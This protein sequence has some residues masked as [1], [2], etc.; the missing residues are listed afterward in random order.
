[1][2]T[3]SR[4]NSDVALHSSSAHSSA[5]HT[6]KA[7]AVVK[8]RKLIRASGTSAAITTT[9]SDTISSANTAGNPQNCGSA[10]VSL[11]CADSRAMALSRAQY[12]TSGGQASFQPIRKI[13]NLRWAHLVRHR[14]AVPFQWMTEAEQAFARQLAQ[15]LRHHRIE[16]AMRHEDRRARVRGV[17]LGRNDFRDRQIG[18]KRDDAAQRLR[19]PD[20]TGKRDRATLREPGQDHAIGRHAALRLALYQHFHLRDGGAD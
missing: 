13:G 11:R 9:S 3:G 7:V 17:A 1:M 16:R 19:M 18:G 20:A 15:H 2:R 14:V 10:T 8:P 12:A 6:A 5:S 4:A